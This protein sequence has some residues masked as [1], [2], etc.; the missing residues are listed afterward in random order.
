[1]NVAIVYDRLNKIGGAE[2]VLI[3]FANLFPNADW[4]TSVWDP[5]G[6]PF[7]R[8]WKVYTSWINKIP[9]LRTRHELIPYLMPFVF[10]SFNLNAYDLVISIGSAESK[11]VLTKPGTVHLNYCLT[12]TRYLYSHSIEYL[13]NPIYR[14]I[15]R[16]L[17]KWDLVASTRP[18]KMIAI[19]TQVKKRIKNVYSREVDVIFPPVDVKK[20]QIKS[21]FVPK[22][23]D[24]YL[25][26]ARLV[27]YKKIDLLV[28][29]F[30]KSGRTLI[31]VGNGSEYNKLKKLAN[32][33]VHLLGSRSDH[34]LVG[35]YQ[36]AKAFLQ[37]N[38]EDFG[39]SMCEAQAAGIPVIAYHKGGAA[40]I[41][42]DGKTGILVEHTDPDSF[43]RAIDRLETL[44]F[45]REVCKSNAKRF[46]KAIW[47]KQIKERIN[48]L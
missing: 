40:D 22:Y 16:Y 23:S 14:F 17:R 28:R 9:F 15:A 10:E 37:A 21:D 4:Y 11:G 3:E 6:A 13:S 5:S 43:N 25:T 29:A 7:S 30:N 8:S 35:Y 39:I 36:H 31:I 44:T 24:Y 26:V 32:S 46:D 48:N 27:Q 41:V 38:E 20:F 12:P 34:E 18:D 19:S 45:D 2:A 42:I 33:N 47:I 1:M